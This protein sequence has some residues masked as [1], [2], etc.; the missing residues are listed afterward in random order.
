M[1]SNNSGGYITKSVGMNDVLLGRGAPI[2]N[3]EGNVRFR[4]LVNER[5]SRYLN[6]IRHQDK[7]DV[8]QE[9]VNL[10]DSRGGRFL[11]K[12][13]RSHDK[14]KLGIC[15]DDAGWITA[16]DYIIFQ[17]VKQALREIDKKNPQGRGKLR[18]KS[19]VVVSEDILSRQRP[20]DEVSFPVRQDEESPGDTSENRSPTSC[21]QSKDSAICQMMI[22]QFID[23][24]RIASTFNAPRH[25]YMSQ[26][27]MKVQQQSCGIS[28][29][30]SH[31]PK[32]SL[33][34]LFPNTTSSLASLLGNQQHHRNATKDNLCHM[35]EHQYIL[36]A[37]RELL[38]KNLL[39]TS[40][41]IPGHGY[42]SPLLSSKIAE[43]VSM[44]EILRLIQSQRYTS[45]MSTNTSAVASSGSPSV[46]L[47]ASGGSITIADSSSLFD[48]LFERSIALN[49]EREARLKQQRN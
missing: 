28:E 48:I 25:V 35:V 31:Y 37:K 27:T 45:L 46:P 43:T 10:I 16:D 13:E 33:G 29:L 5:K 26:P 11:L 17:K 41:G 18:N 1:T 9:I 6:S 40:F 42:Q 14:V 3:H 34:S 8:A 30:T 2:I 24:H 7:N 44:T 32:A 15:T 23:H 36:R 21:E 47:T 20:V 12:V 49:N 19:K 4:K 38:L 39:P 22:T